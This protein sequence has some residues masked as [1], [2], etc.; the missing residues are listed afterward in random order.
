M[1][2]SVTGNICWMSSRYVFSVLLQLAHDRQKKTVEWPRLAMSRGSPFWTGKENPI[3]SDS[4]FT[5]TPEEKVRAVAVWFWKR[6]RENLGQPLLFG[7]SSPLHSI[8]LLLYSICT[9]KQCSQKY[10]FLLELDWLVNSYS[11]W[12]STLIIPQEQSPSVYSYWFRYVINRFSFFS[13]SYSHALLVPVILH[14]LE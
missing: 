7:R 8:C 5:K 2:G 12:H 3:K 11:K 10:F 4:V 6:C 14:R 13:K 9:Y 1:S